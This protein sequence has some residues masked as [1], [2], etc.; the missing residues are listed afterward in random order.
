MINF[1]NISK[2]QLL[3]LIFTIFLVINCQSSYA[4]A[5]VEL[6]VS[7]M[8][9]INSNTCQVFINGA[10]WGDRQISFIV[11]FRINA[12]NGD[13]MNTA[14]RLFEL[15]KG[16]IVDG[17][18]YVDNERCESI[19]SLSIQNVNLCTVD[20]SVIGNPD[21]CRKVISTIKGVIPINNK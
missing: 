9:F 15:R 16:A 14:S 7:K 12:K 18:I 4:Q 10:N 8:L 3:R 2:S 21:L 19:G 6:S 5:K 13:L 20:G 1:Y 17:H 11:N